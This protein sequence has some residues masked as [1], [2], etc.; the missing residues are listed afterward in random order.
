M[1]NAPPKPG[2]KITYAGEDF[3]A[4]EREESRC[5]ICSFLDDPIDSPDG[6]KTT[7]RCGNSPCLGV[8]WVP[9]K[10]YITNRLTT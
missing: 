9:L 10:V 1:S 2:S 5:A 6:P 7:N 3:Y 4:L 8:A